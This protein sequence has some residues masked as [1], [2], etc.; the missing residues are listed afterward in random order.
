MKGNHLPYPGLQDRSAEG[1][2][3]GPPERVNSRFVGDEYISSTN[4]SSGMDRRFAGSASIH[5]HARLFG[6]MNDVHPENLYT[7]DNDEAGI[8]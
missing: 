3:G 4:P 8:P 1:I 6:L 5:S 7:D 2:V